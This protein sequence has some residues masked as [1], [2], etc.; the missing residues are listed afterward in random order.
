MT[1][2]CWRLSQPARAITRSWQV[3]RQLDFPLGST[4]YPVGDAD[5]DVTAEGLRAAGKFDKDYILFLRGTARY[6]F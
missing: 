3:N 4:L 1:A 6:L 2:C 5:I